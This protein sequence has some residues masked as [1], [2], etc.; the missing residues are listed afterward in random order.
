MFMGVWIVWLLTTIPLAN[1]DNGSCIS[2]VVGC[3]DQTA[4]NFNANANI[5]DSLSCRYSAGCVTG[6]SIPYW[7]NDPCYAWV[8]DID[9]YCCENEWDTVCQATYNYCEGTWVGPLPF[10]TSERVN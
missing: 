3:M 7:L 6:D 5:D 1:T 9:N 4:Y 10:R 2:I 8:I